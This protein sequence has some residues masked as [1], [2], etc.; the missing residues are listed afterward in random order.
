MWLW[1][2]LCEQREQIKLGTTTVNLT[3]NQRVV[4][5]ITESP[6]KREKRS[7]SG[8][9]KYARER[10]RVVVQHEEPKLWFFVL[11]FSRNLSIVGFSLQKDL[12]YD[13]MCLR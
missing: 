10:K 5:E 13:T 12:I 6:R 2:I 9:M 3:V 11:Y 1:S 7:L 8:K 4:C